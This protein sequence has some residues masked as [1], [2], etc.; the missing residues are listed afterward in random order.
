MNIKVVH[1]TELTELLLGLFQKE[2]FAVFKQ[3]A[4]L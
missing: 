1:N 4:L 2:A 3:N